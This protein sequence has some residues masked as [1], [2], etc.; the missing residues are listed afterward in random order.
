MN[1]KFLLVLLPALALVSCGSRELSASIAEPVG[2][3]GRTRTAS[4][5]PSPPLPGG[6]FGWR[7][8]SVTDSLPPASESAPGSSSG[9]GAP[10]GNGSATVT[11][12]PPATP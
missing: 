2:E 11:A 3:P 9:T 4:Q 10:S 5:S 1:I 8:P 6:P 12:R 7:V